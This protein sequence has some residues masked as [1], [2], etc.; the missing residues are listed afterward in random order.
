MILNSLRLCWSSRVSRLRFLAIQ[1]PVGITSPTVGRTAVLCGGTSTFARGNKNSTVSSDSPVLKH[2][3]KTAE[4]HERPAAQF[5]FR[6]SLELQNGIDCQEHLRVVGAVIEWLSGLVAGEP[7]E[8]DFWSQGQVGGGRPVDAGGHRIK[9]ADKGHFVGIAGAV[10][11]NACSIF[12]AKPFEPQSGFP[13]IVDCV[14]EVLIEA[15][16]VRRASVEGTL[17][18]R[19]Q[20]LMEDVLALAANRQRYDPA[21][22]SAIRKCVCDGQAAWVIDVIARYDAQRSPAAISACISL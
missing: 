5:A 19:P 4:A 6:K 8:A 2:T 16:P 7:V 9:V 20:P 17:L 13:A 3:P 18:L 21:I 11:A 1:L 14:E 15:V 10:Q 12:I 22:A